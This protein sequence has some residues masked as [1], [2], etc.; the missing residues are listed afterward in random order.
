MS[1]YTIGLRGIDK[2]MHALVGGKAANL[3][4]LF[5]IEGIAIPDGF[6]ITTNAYKEI[7]ENNNELSSL[8]DHL[9]SI[10][11]YNR[12]AISE[13]CAAI[14]SIIEN[15]SI[16]D[17]I[18]EAIET[19]RTQYGN[20]NAYA[21]RSS[22]TAEDLST[23][24]FAGQQD[25][26]LNISGTTLILKYI[27]KCWASLFTDRAV[28]YRIQNNI[29]H[30]DVSLAVIIQYMIFPE[31]SG[32]MF[33][34]DP[35]SNN[36]KLVLIDASFGLGE[37][38]VSGLVNAD[39]YKVRGGNVTE[40]IIQKK[41]LAV[42]AQKEGGTQKQSVTP[43]TQY[44]QTLSD[45]QL[46]ELEKTG[47]KI[48]KHFRHPQDIEW[49]I[50]N[51]D[52][53]I[54]QSR[55]I[56]TLFPVP[57]TKDNAPHVYLSVGHQQM[58]TDA[59]M[60]LG[61]SVRQ[62]TT[63]RFMAEAGGR[64]FADVAADLAVPA[65]RNILINVL[66]SIDPLIK[67]ALTN[68]IERGDFIQTLHE[69]TEN[70]VT[71]PPSPFLTLQDYPPGIVTELISKSETVIA[72]LQHNI[73]SVSGPALIDFILDD[74][75]DM[76]KTL[77]DPKYFGVIMTSMNAA[78]WINDKMQLWL[79]EKN[80]VDAVSQSLPDNVTSEMG[81]E[82]LN[83]ADLIRP[84]PAIIE[85]LQN[86]NNENYLEELPIFEGG[87]G[88]QSAIMSFLNKYGMRCA[89]EID[90]TRPRWSEKPVTIIPMLLGN[91]R[92]S[93]QGASKQRFEQGLKLAASKEQE[94][95]QKL[96]VLPESEEKIKETK[97]MIHLV[98]S[99]AGYREYPK[100][101]IVSRYW[102]Y[103]KALLH[104]AEKLVQQ[105]ILHQK[106]DIYFL[107]MEEIKELFSTHQ[108]DYQLINKRKEDQQ[109]FEKLQPPRVYTSDG[110]IITGKYKRENIIPGALIGL[111][112][113]SGIIEGRARVIHTLEEANLKEGDILVTTFTDPSWTPL[114]LS[115]K[116]L[117]TEVGGL[118]THGS[119]IAREYGLP[120]VVGVE[121]ATSLI[122][123]GQQIRVNGTDGII[124]IV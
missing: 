110:E 92:N 96:S 93:Q 116:G 10:P 57:E 34:A 59:M 111:G 113:S 123:D 11:A 35:V 91:I 53:Y 41:K 8:L 99:L 121:R 30:Q 23:A 100:Y 66:G 74:L 25:S 54:V 108:A 117:V 82:L 51:N 72:A 40:K 9:N 84:F 4:E 68:I 105:N 5:K 38:L 102:I 69:E 79:G 114:F 52:I 63:G 1:A 12:T 49:C 90:I 81:L 60:P 77:A 43:E 103:K 17:H 27:R 109:F 122:K 15:I 88:I 50:A 71:T 44:Q 32:I 87:K 64:M 86:T 21:I 7:F 118:M 76:R 107:R 22:A 45:T 78:N 73:Q 101:E 112:V 62:L 89:G 75:Q 26:W 28:L 18:A 83:I 29:Q 2:T 120:A 85:F 119:V 95:L 104:E 14:R 24:S 61:L 42:I 124:E 58:M 115:I 80:C 47:R 55:P 31:V 36:R 48:E 67:D 46:F 98:R 39:H 37:A 70:N 56:T 65:K 97:R 6:C 20:Q 3:G 13:T 16:P 94:L 33:T 19:K 106:Q